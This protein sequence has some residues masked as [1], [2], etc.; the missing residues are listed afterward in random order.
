MPHMQEEGFCAGSLITRRYVLSAGHCIAGA[1][2]VEI[3]FGAHN[4]NKTESS[5]IRMT[6]NKFRFH[7]DIVIFF[8]LN[9]LVLIE[10]PEAVPLSG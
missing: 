8:G 7:E 4:I 9:D 5:Q 2:K 3:V 6:S 10:L 1:N